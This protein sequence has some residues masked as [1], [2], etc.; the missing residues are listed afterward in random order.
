[1]VEKH[2]VCEMASLAIV[3]PSFFSYVPTVAGEFAR[4][5]LTPLVV[6]EKHSNSNAAK[7]FYRLGMGNWYLSPLPKYLAET[8]D[9]IVDAGCSDVLIISPEVIDRKFVHRL[10]DKGLKI[11]L[12]SWDGSSNKGKYTEYLDLLSGKGTFDP[13][14]AEHFGMEYFPL[15]ALN[16]FSS[17]SEE[18]NKDKMYDIS[19]C[20]TMHSSRS[21]ILAEII[22]IARKR[23]LD[24]KLM[25]YYHSRLLYAF[26]SLFDW[27]GISLLGQIRSR[28]FEKGE[29]AM[30]MAQSHFVLDIAHPRQAGMTAR[31]FEALL[32]GARL[33]TNNRT[34]VER[35]PSSLRN[36]VVL[37]ESSASIS[38]IDFR[39]LELLPPLDH[40]ERYELSLERFVDQLCKLMGLGIG[41]APQIDSEGSRA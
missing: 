10:Y 9:K 7:I 1:M 38:K 8:A 25:L 39:A 40:A 5:G 31:T 23:K 37:F 20:G 15:F 17:V 33:L 13:N 27:S 3:G 32:S 12:Y 2:S 41:R 6:D 4:R 18:Y 28:S 26:R 30:S 21:K 34:A 22:A 16:D 24:L 35:L 19:F 11:H 14:D 29:I 36:R